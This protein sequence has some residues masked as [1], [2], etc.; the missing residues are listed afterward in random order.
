MT[1]VVAHNTLNFIEI[2][3]FAASVW[4]SNSWVESGGRRTGYS[5]KKRS[6]ALQGYEQSHLR[7]TR[8]ITREQAKNV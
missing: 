8:T 2:S 5:L 1:Q 4:F 6:S 7:D 3:P